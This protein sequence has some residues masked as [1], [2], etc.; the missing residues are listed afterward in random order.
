MHYTSLLTQ[1]TV[2]ILLVYVLYAKG[3]LLIYLLVNLYFF[4][5]NILIYNIASRA[6]ELNSIYVSVHHNPKV[7]AVQYSVS[8]S[9]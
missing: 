3:R 8:K 6:G 2:L 4:V 7:H 9:L 5:Q 1:R